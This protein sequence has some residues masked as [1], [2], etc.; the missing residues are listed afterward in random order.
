MKELLKELKRDSYR[1]A[2]LVIAIVQI[3]TLILFYNIPIDSLP[4]GWTAFF[5]IGAINI[6]LPWIYCFK[7]IDSKFDKYRKIYPN[8]KTIAIICDSLDLCTFNY[9]IFQLEYEDFVSKEP[10]DREKTVNEHF[11]L[12]APVAPLHYY[13]ILDCP[14]NDSITRSQH[15]KGLSLKEFCIALELKNLLL[16]KPYDNNRIFRIAQ[17]HYH[18]DFNNF[19]WNYSDNF[20]CNSSTRFTLERSIVNY[21]EYCFFN[22]KSP[23]DELF[24]DYYLKNYKHYSTSS[25]ETIYNNLKQLTKNPLE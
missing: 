19:I 24:L 18:I 3:A 17:L 5:L 23:L 8:R 13:V 14:L 10:Y 12:P 9:H 11:P 21:I 20:T 16:N 25:E 6:S 15:A 2:V 1:I 7:Y 4:G 22:R